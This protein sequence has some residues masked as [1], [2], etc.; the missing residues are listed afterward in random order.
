MKKPLLALIAIA[1]LALLGGSA[2]RGSADLTKPG[3]IRLTTRGLAD[4]F[5]NRGGSG[6]DAGDLI[7]IRELLFNK[8]IR[9]QAIGH[10]ELVCTFT[11][12]YSRQCSG[13]FSLPRGK[14]VVSGS[15]VYRQFYVLAVVGGT[16][17]YDNVR[18][19]LTVTMISNKPRRDLVYFRLIN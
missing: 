7:V 3:I 17:L 1:M 13:T 11:T 19:S 10:S 4:Q 16:G 8:G 18:G 9:R 14:I 12:P 5:V 15:L 2:T 6:R